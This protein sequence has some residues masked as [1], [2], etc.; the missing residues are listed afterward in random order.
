MCAG[1]EGA[2]LWKRQP[3]GWLGW[4]EIRDVNGETNRLSPVSLER[5]VQRRG[6]FRAA[7]GGKGKMKQLRGV[8]LEG[9]WCQRSLE[10]RF[11]KFLEE[12]LGFIP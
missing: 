9:T 8:P 1:R 5:W 6:H 7:S 11:W 12:A 3:E 2:G 10:H 4:L